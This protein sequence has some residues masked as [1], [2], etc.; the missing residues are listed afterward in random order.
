MA[1]I[2]VSP[3]IHMRKPDCPRGWYQVTKDLMKSQGRSPLERGQC[4]HKNPEGASS[5]PAWSLPRG[6]SV[7]DAQ[8][9]RTPTVPALPPPRPL[10]CH[11]SPSVTLHWSPASTARSEFAL[12]LLCSASAS[13]PSGHSEGCPRPRPAPGAGF[14]V[15]PPCWPAPRSR[16]C[17]FRG[18]THPP[19]ALFSQ[20]V[21]HPLR[22]CLEVLSSEAFAGPP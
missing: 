19:P 11:P 13:D 15:S 1:R 9:E 5:L 22:P 7:T 12:P 2:F 10:N 16:L 4:F 20:T 18:Q 6:C 8:A 3:R 14:T 21:R 17:H